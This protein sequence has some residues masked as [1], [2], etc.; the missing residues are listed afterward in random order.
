[1]ETFAE[2]VASE[3]SADVSLPDDAMRRL[4][5]LSE[6]LTRFGATVGLAGFDTEESRFHRYFG[7]PLRCLGWLS[8]LAPGAALDIGSGGG[9]P[10]LPLAIVEPAQDWLLLEPR[11]RKALFLEQEI[12]EL[13]VENARVIR[14]R[15]EMMELAPAGFQLV[16]TR[17]V[18]LDP[19]AWAKLAHILCPGGLFLW[20]TGTD[21]WRRATDA[22]TRGRTWSV[23]AESDLSQRGVRGSLLV[24][25][26]RRSIS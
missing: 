17:G 6:D 8:G 13:G 22:L 12:H 18:A 23:E 5:R 25:L 16:T 11:R 24:V 3:L 20:F 19:G 21:V 7:E 14:N 15:F 26:R 9:S 1:M 10:A 2:R 4:E